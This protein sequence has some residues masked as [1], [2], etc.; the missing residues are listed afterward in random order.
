MS[1]PDAERALNIYRTFCKQTDLVVAYLSVA[2]LHEHST[3]LEIPKIKH[4]PTSLAKSLEEYLKDKDFE[5]NRRQYLAE[6][7]AKKHGKTTNGALGR[8]TPL[9]SAELPTSGSKP[10]ELSSTATRSATTTTTTKQAPEKGPAPDLIDF[11]E[12]IEQNQQPLGQTQNA[13]QFQ[14]TSQFQQQQS[15][16]PQQ[17]SSFPGQIPGA[18][19][20]QPFGVGYGQGTNPFGQQQTQQIQ[21]SFTGAGF[22]GYTPQPFSPSSSSLSPIPQD[23]IASFPQQAQ[24]QQQQQQP[25]NFSTGQVSAPLQQQATSTNPFRQSI[26]QNS[27]GLAAGA[28]N[29]PTT[30]STNPF[31]KS[32]QQQTPTGS[33]SAFSAASSSPFSS[34]PTSSPFTNPSASSLPFVMN[35]QTP[36]DMY[37]TMPSIPAVH[38]PSQSPQSLQPATTGI[39]PFRHPSPNQNTLSPS[40]PSSGGGLVPNPTGSTNPFRQSAFVNPATGQG[41]QSSQGTMGGLEHLETTKVFP[42]PGQPTGPNGGGWS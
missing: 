39:N 23:S 27:P 38:P 36:S 35:Q 6:Q 40:S 5:I 22:G 24:Q 11:F 17:Q 28:Q 10:A 8:S 26:M 30:K 31:A 3:R 33:S 42:R 16:I 15:F 9:K 41:W 19:P 20:Q 14:Q 4:A 21:P 12:S 32:T 13:P 2:R 37:S 7:E 25:Q 1:H 34:Q 18:Q 29:S